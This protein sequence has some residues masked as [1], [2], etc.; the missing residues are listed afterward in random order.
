MSLF[1]VSSISAFCICIGTQLLGK[2]NESSL[3]CVAANGF[4]KTY[5]TGLRPIKYTLQLTYI[6][7]KLSK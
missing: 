2:V 6:Y 5:S 4:I 7:I 1:F 3:L